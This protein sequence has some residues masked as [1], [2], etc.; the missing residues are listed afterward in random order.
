MPRVVWIFPRH[1]LY[2]PFQHWGAAHVGDSTLIL[3]RDLTNLHQA[4]KPLPWI[5]FNLTSGSGTLPVNPGTARRT[6]TRTKYIGISS[7]SS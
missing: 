4:R 7:W 1:Q 6:A 2:E 3:C 5:T